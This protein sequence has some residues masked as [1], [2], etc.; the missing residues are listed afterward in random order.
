[1]I[2]TEVI[3][4]QELT[5]ALADEVKR[6][7]RFASNSIVVGFPEDSGNHPE[8]DESIVE[9][10][11]KLEFGKW[12]FLRKGVDSVLPDITEYMIGGAQGVV[13]GDMDIDNVFD[14]IG[15]IAV[16]GVH[17]FMD[18]LKSPSNSPATIKIKGFNNYKLNIIHYEYSN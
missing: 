18:D 7:A 13:S 4:G 11:A 6:I 2:K 5:K 9:I 8:S 16:S 10:A 3:G 1:M 15:T 14:G 17:V 12:P